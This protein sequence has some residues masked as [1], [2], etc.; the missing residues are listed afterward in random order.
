MLNAHFQEGSVGAGLSFAP[1]MDRRR[2]GPAVF[3]PFVEPFVREAAVADEA[4]VLRPADQILV[5][6]VNLSEHGRIPSE[7]G[8]VDLDLAPVGVADDLA[9]FG[10][11]EIRLLQVEIDQRGR[12]DVRR[13]HDRRFDGLRRHVVPDGLIE[14]VKRGEI[15]FFGPP[16][17]RPPGFAQDVRHPAEVFA[18]ISARRPGVE[19]AVDL[20]LTAG[21]QIHDDQQIGE[22]EG[23]IS[24]VQRLEETAAHVEP[25]PELLP[26]IHGT[27]ASAADILRRSAGKAAFRF[28]FG[29]CGDG[30]CF[31]GFL[32]PANRP[33]RAFFPWRR[34]DRAI[35]TGAQQERRILPQRDKERNTADIWRTETNSM[36][37]SGPVKTAIPEQS[38]LRFRDPI[39]KWHTNH[40]A[41]GLRDFD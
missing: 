9:K 2:L 33:G 28:L 25:L 1:R 7:V 20:L 6:L 10:R 4:G 34:P 5:S 37:P 17:L 22:V 18:R 39:F 38:L 29:L 16:L 30:Q 14:D 41:R 11:I 23:G 13:M 15:S 35:T 27:V 32:H 12:S 19:K 26:A 8:M 36:K 40:A 24:R 31:H 3:V 21:Q